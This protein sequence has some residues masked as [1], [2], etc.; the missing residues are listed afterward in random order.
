MIEHT[1]PSASPE[2]EIGEADIPDGIGDGPTEPIPLPTESHEDGDHDPEEPAWP[3]TSIPTQPGSRNPRGNDD[4]TRQRGKRFQQ[5]S[6]LEFFING[7]NPSLDCSD[8][9]AR[10]FV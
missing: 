1:S 6:S 10:K 5:V 9:V 8:S 3:P 4:S 2:P 7:S